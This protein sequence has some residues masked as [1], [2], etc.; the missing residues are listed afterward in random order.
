MTQDDLESAE[1]SAVPVVDITS[2]GFSSVSAENSKIERSNS[3]DEQLKGYAHFLDKLKDPSAVPLVEKVKLFVSRFPRDLGREQATERL[4]RF[5][6][7]LE[8]EVDKAE[9][10]AV[11]SEEERMDAK[12]GLEK[13]ILKPLHQYFFRIDPDDRI[14]DEEL[15]GK[16]SRISPVIKLHDH[17][18]GPSELV[19]DSLL[20]LAVDEMRRMD[21]YR[22][23]RDKLQC[24]LNAFRVIRHALD[25]V[26]GP[27]AWGA[28]QLLPVCIYTIIRANPPSLNSNINFIASFR[29]PSRLRGEDEYLL[30]Q[31]NIAIRDIMDIEEVLLKPVPSLTITDL[32][33]MHKR[34]KRNL[35]RLVDDESGDERKW[36]GLLE[37]EWQVGNVEA[38]V[39]SY[40]LV[41]DEFN[42]RYN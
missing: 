21:S 35:H 11:S 18:H 7:L 24:I 31:M 38:F 19:D 16:I 5:I 30:M 28:D 29:H 25:T 22:A 9:V 42:R 2:P 23:P 8:A 41:I 27:S 37:T 3:T 36:E 12:E 34:M 10:F 15:S 33:R 13:L 40:K 32:A 26:I 1:G 17:L 39:E 4:H 14:L 20:D 6:S